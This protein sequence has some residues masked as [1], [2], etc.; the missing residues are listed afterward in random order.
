[1]KNT[2]QLWFNRGRNPE[3][4]VTKAVMKRRP[5]LLDPSKALQ[6]KVIPVKLVWAL[7]E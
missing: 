4:I 2:V 3:A 7:T 1:M 6:Y 5:W